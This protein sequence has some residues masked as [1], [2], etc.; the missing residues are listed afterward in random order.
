MTG[1]PVANGR[2]TQVVKTASLVKKCGA[3]PNAPAFVQRLFSFVHRDYG[4]GHRYRR[5]RWIG[6][7]FLPVYLDWPARLP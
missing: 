5:K 4:E 6:D 3:F 2:G 1:T 7:P